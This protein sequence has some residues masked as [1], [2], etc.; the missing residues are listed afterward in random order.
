MTLILASGSRTRQSLL[1]NAGLDFEVVPA[2]IDERAAEAPL[3][4]AGAAPEDLALALAM[5]KAV[6]VSERRPGDL[7]I[8]ADQVLD[9]DGER[10][11]KPE[12]MEAARRQLL[13]LSGRTHQLH[14]A[15]ACARGGEVIWEHLETASLT[16]RKLEPGFVGRHLARAGP[17]V[18]GSVGAYQLE[19][20]GIQ[21]F[22][23]IEGEYFTI[24]GLPLLPLL[25]FLRSEGFVE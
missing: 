13:S 1:A 24:L 10:L 22:E 14:A 8:G 4:E 12:N 6:S 11:T 15:I 19:G 16:V 17:A 20:P 18:L 25:A 5:T 21:L 3:R 23:R 7:V 2:D 9:L